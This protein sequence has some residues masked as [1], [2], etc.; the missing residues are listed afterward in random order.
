MQPTSLQV[1]L[2]VGLPATF[3]V[4]FQHKNTNTLL[5]NISSGW[6]SSGWTCYYSHFNKQTIF[7]KRSSVTNYSS[8][9]LQIKKIN[10][11]TWYGRR[12]LLCAFTMSPA[13]LK[14]RSAG[15]LV[16]GMHRKISIFAKAKVF[17]HTGPQCNGGLIISRS[18][19]S[20]L[21]SAMLCFVVFALLL[22]RGDDVTDR[23]TDRV[24]FNAFIIKRLSAKKKHPYKVWCA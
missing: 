1:E 24:T 8:M 19:T 21:P 17:P 15:T 9:T 3:A 12:T 10:W 23:Q 14:T 13:V 5:T 20:P 16:P 22:A 4:V 2:T 7:N 18:S 11:S 6:M